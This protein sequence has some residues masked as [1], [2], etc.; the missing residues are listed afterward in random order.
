[1]NRRPL[2]RTGL[3]VSEIG[4]G[5]WGIGNTG[6]RGADD[7]QS[8]RALH[9]ALDLGLN[10]ID[11][12]L[13]YG[14]GHSERLIGRV[15][16]E[17]GPDDRTV[18]ASKVPP[19]NAQWP[20]RPGVPAAEAFP[21]DHVIACTEA[22]LRNLG[23]ETIDLQQFHVW[24]DEWL[25]QGDWLAAIER[26]KRD[27]KIRGFGVSVND[28]EPDSALA[29]IASGLVDTVQVVY[30]IFEQ[31]PQDRLFPACRAQGVGVI[32]R[33][34]LGEGGLTGTVTAQSQFDAD[35][36]RSRYFAGERK[37]ELD[38]HVARLLGDLRVDVADLPELALRFALSP[39]PVCTVIPG[40]R[41]VR[42]VERNCALA[43][44]RGLSTETLQ[45]L[46][47]YRWT[48]NFY[49]TTDPSQ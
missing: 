17:R 28:C 21:A 15:L 3:Q 30:S 13:V 43:D 7:A 6:W 40:M 5:A 12:A 23:R 39:E 11:T 4:Y 45:R 42:N 37:R 16:H 41:S 49:R 10:F 34:P 46:Q 29:L 33:A 31:A 36:F 20:A 19:R 8:C 14:D 18:V 35:D 24:S 1:V 38:A 22:S 26:L 48:R 32:V 25:R 47:A 27:G 9:R 2:G 44:G